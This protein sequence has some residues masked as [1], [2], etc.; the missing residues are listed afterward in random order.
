MGP[1]QK[2]LARLRSVQIFVAQVGLGPLK[3]PIF[4][5]FCPLGQKNLI[6]SG[7]KVL[8]SKPGQP[9][10]YFLSK[11]KAYLQYGSQIHGMM[12]R[13][14][15]SRIIN[16]YKTLT[17]ASS[18]RRGRGKVKKQCNKNV[19]EGGRLAAQKSTSLYT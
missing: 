9:L 10:I 12:P 17:S 16:L 8:W 1:G 15:S 4:L 11:V 14:R 19:K 5:I 13:V 18:C 6:V 3:I 2:F 7:Q